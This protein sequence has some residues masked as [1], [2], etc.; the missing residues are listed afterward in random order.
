MSQGLSCKNCNTD[1]FVLAAPL[2]AS[3]QPSHAQIDQGDSVTLNCTVHGNPIK[4]ITWRKNGQPLVL[5]SRVNL[6]S[7]TTLHIREVQGHDEAMY[8]CFVSNDQDSAQ[9]SAQLTLG[10]KCKLK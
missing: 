2:S 7:Q 8:Q 1:R 4:S 3:I 10:S 5:S 6:T 9:A